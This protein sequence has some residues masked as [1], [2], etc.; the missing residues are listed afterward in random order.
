VG[1]LAAGHLGP[2]GA[3]GP[4]GSGPTGPTGPQGD[5]GATGATGPAGEGGGLP[6]VMTGVWAV[7]GEVGVEEGETPMQASISYMQEIEPAP[8]LVYV[9]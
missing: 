6:D 8:D 9:F 2:T 5:K 4:G 7:D 3:T 1:A